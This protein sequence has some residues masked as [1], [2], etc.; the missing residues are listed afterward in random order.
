MSDIKI[1]NYMEDCV[2]DTLETLLPSLNVCACERCRMDIMAYALN[3]LPP[4]YVVTRLGHLYTKLS[5]MHS[6]FE[7]DIMTNIT[8]G[9]KLISQNPRH[10]DE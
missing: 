5:G 7:V 10:G 6:Q 2:A 1:K 3:K 4:K 8:Q 9:A